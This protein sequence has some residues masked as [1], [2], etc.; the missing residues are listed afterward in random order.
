MAQQWQHFS[1]FVNILNRISG[2]FQK[3]DWVRNPIRKCQDWD[4]TWYIPTSSWQFKTLLTPHYLYQTLCTGP[5]SL[6]LICLLVSLSPTWPLFIPRSQAPSADHL[7]YSWSHIIV[8]IILC[9]QATDLGS[10]L[11]PLL[12]SRS[13]WQAWSSLHQLVCPMWQCC[14][15]VM[16]LLSAC[17]LTLVHI[18][19]QRWVLWPSHRHR[20][21]SSNFL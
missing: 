19:E 15:V 5:M 13:A 18:S 21:L 10:G 4:K 12:R 6:S 1:L 3:L 2:D 8:T 7:Q 14:H 11:L 9:Y 17:Y 20:R 16:S